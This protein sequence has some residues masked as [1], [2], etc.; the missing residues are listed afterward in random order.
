MSSSSRSAIV[1]ACV[2][3]SSPGGKA[4]RSI[5]SASLSCCGW[6][7]NRIDPRTRATPSGRYQIGDDQARS[8]MVFGTAGLQH[9]S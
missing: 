1:S 5:L 4:P 6:G 7:R 8:W 2:A 9:S 3:G